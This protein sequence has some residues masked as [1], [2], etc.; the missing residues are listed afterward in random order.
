MNAIANLTEQFRK[1][2][3]PTK[4]LSKNYHF[5]DMLAPDAPLR[6]VPMA[7]FT[8]TPFSYRNA[9]FGVLSDCTDASAQ[10]HAHRALGAAIWFCIQGDQVEVWNTGGPTGAVR[11][12]VHPLAA[13]DQL[14]ETHR[15]AWAPDRIHQAKLTGLWD[16][17][18]Q[19]SFF[20]SGLI[21][22]IEKHTQERLDRI[23]TRTLKTLA[24]P[25]RAAAM[26]F[27]RAY[28]PCFYFVAAKIVLDR[29]HPVG[30]N[31]PVN[32]AQGILDAISAHYGLSY[33]AEPGKG[34]A[35]QRLEEAWIALRDDVSFAN[36]SADDLA[37]VYENT[38]VSPETRQELGTHS[39]PRAVAEFLISRL[40]L[41][42]Y[43]KSVPKIYEPF[44]G[45][46]VL[47]VAA[48]STIRNHLPREWTESQRH[49]FL[50]RRLRGSDVDPFACE[51]A[52][53]S[54]ILADYPSSNGWDIRPA[55]LFT[56]ATLASQLEPGMVVVCNPPFE[57]FTPTERARY[58]SAYASSVRKPIQVLNTVLDSKPSAIAFVMP[59]A[60]IADSQY[61]SLR[62][63]IEREFNQIE[64]V[65]LPDRVFVQADFESALLIGRDPR[66]EGRASMVTV[67][68]ATV[69]DAQRENFL[70]GCHRPEFR[71]RTFHSDPLQTQGSLWVP[72]MSELWE[73]LVNYP[74]LSSIAELHRGLEWQSGHQ[75]HAMSHTALPGFKPG[76]HSSAQLCQFSTITPVYLDCRQNNLRGG[77]IALPWDQPKVIL[78]A[79]RKSRGA[80][81]LAAT[82]DATGLVIS[83]QLAGC[84]PKFKEHKWLLTIAAI[85]NSPLASAYIGIFDSRKRFRLQ[86]LEDLPIPYHL[87]PD[88]LIPLI[89]KV[90]RLASPRSILTATQDDALTSALLALDAAIL[91]AYA[92]PPRLERQ[93]LA[94]FQNAKRPI[95]GEFAGYPEDDGGMARSLDEIL[96]KRFEDTRGHWISE[97]FRPLPI[98]ESELVSS[99]LQ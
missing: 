36:I 52:S 53:L 59:Q 90:H 50:V 6:V 41:G 97:V 39:T 26:D 86:V 58:P 31:W 57:N 32:D 51:V 9:A 34:I 62:Q 65:A 44:C 15:Q 40:E 70:A 12:T 35:R 67:R 64:L 19:L 69:S 76:L 21:K 10:I 93:L 84:W 66:P 30:K 13:L 96:A 60:V 8:D 55:D 68:S 29:E 94:Y 56:E 38:L 11:E 48:L 17:P 27:R 45:A 54:L 33:A 16:T 5:P 79:A 78:N 25:L 18:E 85:L 83:Q 80:W 95:E 73:A 88:S 28:R 4:A 20:E 24:T 98:A 99:Y 1:I 46:T 61:T 72:E 14:F 23:I 92:L 42:R 77:A 91:A 87:D 81:R 63:R 37:F 75:A 71:S 2:G 22:L 7:V 43:G 89:E 3:Y 74:T 82:A 47:L 49:A